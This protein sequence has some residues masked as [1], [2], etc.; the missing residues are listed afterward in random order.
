MRGVADPRSVR[1]EVSYVYGF[2]KRPLKKGKTSAIVCCRNRNNVEPR[3][4]RQPLRFLK[5]FT[6]LHVQSHRPD[7]GNAANS[8]SLISCVNETSVCQPQDLIDPTG[9]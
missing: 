3:P 5:G 7:I 4:V 9:L 1:L 8:L 2:A 6:S